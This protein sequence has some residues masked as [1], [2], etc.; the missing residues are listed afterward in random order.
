[1]K[2][3]KNMTNYN[4]FQLDEHQ[5]DAVKKMHQKLAIMGYIKEQ[6]SEPSDISEYYTATEDELELYKRAFYAQ[7]EQNQPQQPNN[8][9]WYTSTD[10]NIVELSENYEG[11][12]PISN[13]Y[14]NGKGVM[15]F[16][17]ELTS[18]GQF[19]FCSCTSLTSIEIPSSVTSIGL[20]AFCSCTS[21]TS[22]TIP[23]SVT[24][25]GLN[26]FGY[27]SSLTSVTISNGV[28]SIGNEA[29]CECSNLTSVNIPSSVT[30]IGLYAF[31]GCSSLTSVTISNGVTSIEEFAFYGCSSL[32]DITIPSSVTSIGNEAF[33]YCSSLT[34]IEIP[35]SVTS[36]GT[37]AFYGC[38]SLTDITFDGTMAQWNAIT[39][40]GGWNDGVHATYVQC[41]D[42]QVQL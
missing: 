37:A 38:S 33:S 5:I 41:T 35:S 13:T 10:R 14:S 7:Y 9:I 18:I 26:A 24:S 21:L 28:T 32:T 15:V 27:C 16:E 2:K 23:S 1:M 20:N 19:A 40:G 17:N 6:G 36:I 11:A 34:S 42:G 22:I 29:F 30:S 25:I 12:R 39:K 3:R 8:E 31:S 4:D